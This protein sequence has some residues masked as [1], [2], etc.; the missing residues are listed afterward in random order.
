MPV[1]LKD[2]S[3]DGVLNALSYNYKLFS[4]QCKRRILSKAQ[5]QAKMGQ[6]RGGTD[7][8]GFEQT[9]VVI[10]AVFEDLALKQ[11]MVKEVEAL[12]DKDIIFASNT[13]SLPIHQIAEGASK[14]E[15]VVGLHYFSPAEKMPLVEVIPHATTSDETVATVVALARKQ[16]KTP[17]VV[18]DSAGFYVN[19]ILAPYMNEAAHVLM[20]EQEIEHIDNALLNF[21]FPVGPITLLDEV[22]VDIGAKI[23][24]ILVKELGDRFQ[25]PDLFDTLLNDGRKGRKVGK[26]FYTYKGKDKKVDKSVYGLLK[27]TPSKSIS[28]DDIAL[29]CVIPLLNEAVRCLDEALLPA[30]EMVISVPSLVLVSLHSPVVHSDSWIIMGWIN[31]SRRWVNL[32]S[33]TAKDLSHVRRCWIGQSKITLSTKNLAGLPAFFLSEFQRG[34]SFCFFEGAAKVVGVLVSKHMRYIYHL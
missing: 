10:E 31:L 24:P 16:G 20:A 2:V 27:L 22:G 5:L 32:S 12:S 1:K 30:Q 33:S 25:G 29:R 15:N 28:E 3:E 13:S 34:F 4:K 6:L 9:Q 21:G 23:M 7:Y 17:I 8:L 18:K 19:R 14:P 26:G 11:S